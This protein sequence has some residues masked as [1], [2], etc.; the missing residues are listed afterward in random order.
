MNAKYEAW[1]VPAHEVMLMSRTEIIRRVMEEKARSEHHLLERFPD[2]RVCHVELPDEGGGL[3][4][5]VRIVES[6]ES[7]T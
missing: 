4:G 5:Y 6:H 7:F 1:I 3:R 2:A